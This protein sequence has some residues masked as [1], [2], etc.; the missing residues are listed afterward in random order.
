MK[1]NFDLLQQNRLIIYVPLEKLFP[2][3]I[4]FSEKKFLNI[5]DDSMMRNYTLRNLME[6][7]MIRCQDT[8]FECFH[9]YLIAVTVTVSHKFTMVTNL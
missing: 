6:T 3:V 4:L 8:S 2:L 5:Y 7:S 9:S 1:Y